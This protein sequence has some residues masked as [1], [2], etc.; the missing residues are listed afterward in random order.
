MFPATIKTSREL[1]SKCITRRCVEVHPIESE[2][3]INKHCIAD[4]ASFAGCQCPSGITNVLKIM[5][6]T[7]FMFISLDS[8]R[9][10]ALVVNWIRI[11]QPTATARLDEA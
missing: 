5:T 1:V 7:T 9:Y 2:R 4:D 10:E 3:P 6:L 8:S 11:I